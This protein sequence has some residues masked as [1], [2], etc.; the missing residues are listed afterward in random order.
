[1]LSTPLKSIRDKIY[2][3]KQM[4]TYNNV[5]KNNKKMTLQHLCW[6]IKH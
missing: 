6:S 5:Q 1:M 3:T 2:D 4:T